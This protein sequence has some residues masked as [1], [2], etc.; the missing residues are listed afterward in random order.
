MLSDQLSSYAPAV[1]TGMGVDVVAPA[2]AGWKS[3][4][5]PSTYESSGRRVT[6][7]SSKSSG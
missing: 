2:A 5:S 7:W 3:R 4:V 1:L 6:V